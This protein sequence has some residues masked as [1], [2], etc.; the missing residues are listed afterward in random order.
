MRLDDE[1]VAIVR[2]N[3]EVRLRPL[4]SGRRDA[5]GCRERCEVEDIGEF[6]GGGEVGDG[7]IVMYLQLL[8]RGRA[9]QQPIARGLHV[10]TATTYFMIK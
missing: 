10:I 2:R 5:I 6:G 9:Q 8:S 1:D 7:F 4:V 3:W